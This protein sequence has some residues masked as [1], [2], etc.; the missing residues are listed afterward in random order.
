[1]ITLLFL[2]FIGDFLLQSDW[3][4]LNK[5]KRFDALAIHCLVYS[6][7]FIPFL[8]W[9]FATVTFLVHLLTDALTSQATSK[10]WFFDQME[11]IGGGP[12]WRVRPRL[13]RRHW[14]FVMIGFD[15]FLHFTQLILTARYF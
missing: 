8:G 5:S 10:L 12:L 2:H 7:C 13:E 14:F 1:M 3:M 9:R 11:Q 6:A 15:Q 4:A